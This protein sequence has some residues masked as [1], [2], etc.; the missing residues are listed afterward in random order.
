M[1]SQEKL[2]HLSSFIKS[3][4][5]SNLISSD[6]LSHYYEVFGKFKARFVAKYPGKSI[7][8]YLLLYSNI[9]CDRKMPR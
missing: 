9:G 4:Y 1:P 8:L 2:E 5:K 6:K 7:A 3:F